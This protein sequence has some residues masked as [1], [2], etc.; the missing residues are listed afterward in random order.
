[1]VVEQQQNK[2]DIFSYVLAMCERR[3]ERTCALMKFS[4]AFF[5][6]KNSIMY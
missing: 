1:M 3:R 2:T 6:K 4:Q 5:E